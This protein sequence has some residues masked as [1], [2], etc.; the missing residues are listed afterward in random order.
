[1]IEYRIQALSEAIA[2]ENYDSV[3]SQYLKVLQKID[4]LNETKGCL[5]SYR[6]TLFAETESISAVTSSS[7]TMKQLMVRTIH[8]L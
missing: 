7:I 6:D 5:I 2:D 8:L 4:E 1:M 3:N